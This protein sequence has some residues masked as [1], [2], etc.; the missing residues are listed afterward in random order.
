MDTFHA[1]H[2]T[3]CSCNCEKTVNNKDWEEVS[4]NNISEIKGT[5]MQI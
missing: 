2:A 5:L 3:E 4:E 1:V